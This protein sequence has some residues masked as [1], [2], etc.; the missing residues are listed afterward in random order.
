[1]LPFVNLLGA[2]DKLYSPYNGSI[3]QIVKKRTYD[4]F[5]LGRTWAHYKFPD[6]GDDDD[7]DVLTAT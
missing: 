3:T 7:D 6:D 2:Y 1:M 4:P 5:C